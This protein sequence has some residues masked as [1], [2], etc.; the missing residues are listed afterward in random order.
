M[1]V[2][3]DVLAALGSVSTATL[4]L[5]MLKRYGLRTRAVLGARPLSPSRCRFVGPAVTL[6]FA[7]AREDLL[8]DA[9]LDSPANP[10][11][12]AV[13]EL[14]AGSVLVCA[15]SGSLAGGAL[16]D[17]LAA[18]LVARGAAGVVADGAMR[19]CGVLAAMDLPVFC[20]APSAPPSFCGLLAVDR[21]VPVG[22]GGALVYPGDIMVAD[23]DG[24]ICI[25]A[26]YAAELA[27][28]GPEQEALE[29]WI[30][31]RVEAGASTIGLYPP[32]AAALAAFRAE[33]SPASR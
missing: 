31:A 32:D 10:T 22:C 9:V 25:P 5:Q 6:R 24:V 13:E 21:D 3:A 26:R 30:R 7:P 23:E 20:L 11:R 16:G 27:E 1:T 29:A 19:D 4:S 14:P 2:P 8:A 18:R 17:I 33:V 12:G 15:M 28:S